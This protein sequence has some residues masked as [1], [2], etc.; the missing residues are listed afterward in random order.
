MTADPTEAEMEA[1]TV[2]HS[3]LI[4]IQSH[5][6]AKSGIPAEVFEAFAPNRVFPLLIPQGYT[7]RSQG[8]PLVGEPGLYMSVTRCPPH[9]GPALHI[10]PDNIENFFCLEGQFR[11]R[12]RE[13]GDRSLILDKYDM[14]S[15]PPGIY[16]TFE[17]T[18]DEP[19]LLLV[20]V[21]ILSKQ[22]QDDVIISPAESQMLSDK[23]GEDITAKLEKIGFEF[24]RRN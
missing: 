21:H 23:F 15:V 22:Q 13:E 9:S 24:A 10:H 11:I 17:N 4:D 18:T 1:R 14:C 6:R 8:A 16:R 20:V 7:G 5:H 2:R 19:A 3:S 12:W